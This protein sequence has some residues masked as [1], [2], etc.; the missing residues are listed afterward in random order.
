M[1][2]TRELPTLPLHRRKWLSL[3]LHRL[4][5]PRR[6]W[7]KERLQGRQLDL[8]L[9]PSIQS[10]QSTDSQLPL[11]SRKWPDF[12]CTLPLHRHYRLDRM[13]TARGLLMQRR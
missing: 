8:A 1:I 4:K 3:P 13:F 12:M 9:T 6:K 5:R 11:H 10:L 2:I 7:H